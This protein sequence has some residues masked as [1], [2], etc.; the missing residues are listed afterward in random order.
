VLAGP[1]EHEQRGVLGREAQVRGGERLQARRDV[2]SRGVDG[3]AQ[4]RAHP[5]EPGLRE[6]VGH[7]W[8]SEKWRRRA[9]WLTPASR[10]SSRSERACTPRSRGASGLL[11][12]GRP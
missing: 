2:V 1:H 6:H 10:A 8:W 5:G 11:E 12:E 3:G 7:R 4:L 9:P